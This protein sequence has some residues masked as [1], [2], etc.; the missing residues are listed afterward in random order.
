V[1]GCCEAWQGRPLSS[2]CSV[3]GVTAR[4]EGPKKKKTQHQLSLAL[5]LTTL[6][7]SRASR[8]PIAKVRPLCCRRPRPASRALPA[9]AHPPMASCIACTPQPWSVCG[10]GRRGRRCAATRQVGRGARTKRKNIGERESRRAC[11]CGG[12]RCPLQCTTVPSA[13]LSV[14]ADPHSTPSRGQ[15]GRQGCATPCAAGVVFCA[16]RGPAC[17][18]FDAALAGGRGQRRP[19]PRPTARSNAVAA[20]AT[21]LSMPGPAPAASVRGGAARPAPWP[22]AARDRQRGRCVEQAARA[23]GPSFRRPRA[24]SDPSSLLS[25]IPPLGWRGEKTR[26]A[27]RAPPRPT[28]R[29]LFPPG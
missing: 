15:M 7:P 27:P 5:P 29:A 17:A 26:T 3:A 20:P 13:A 21:R 24:R 8:P 2:R 28:T 1:C 11:I 16:Q 6:I 22:A 12:P 18:F 10:R 4:R 19:R 9:L 23:R 25:F 14:T